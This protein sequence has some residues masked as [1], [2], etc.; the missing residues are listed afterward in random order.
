MRYCTG[1]IISSALLDY[2]NVG[3]TTAETKRPLRQRCERLLN[4]LAGDV[5]GAAP[6]WFRQ[7]GSTVTITS[8]NNSGVCPA[9]FDGR[10]GL[11]G[12]VYISGQTINPPLRYMP[13]N[14]LYDLRATFNQS[15]T[16]PKYYTLRD[17]D[18]STF[19]PL[20]QVYPSVSGGTVTL[21]LQN[22]VKALQELVDK[23]TAPTAAVGAATGLTGVYSYV[24]TYV[25]AVGETEAGVVSANVTVANQK[26]NV[27]GIPT[28][29]MHSVTSRNLYRTAAGGAVY[30]LV[31]TIADNTTTTYTD[32]IADVALGVSPPTVLTAVTGT[33]EFPDDFQDSL[34][35]EGLKTELAKSQGDVRD[36][37]WK[38]DWQKEVK[39]KWGQWQQGQQ[40]VVVLPR[41]GVNT[42]M[43]GN[44]G[45]W[46][47]VS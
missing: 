15:G 8:G 5:W 6:W 36:R 32:S 42:G 23:A 20:L 4:S 38:D 3:S 16:V 2:V 30:K 35:L 29:F 9:D 47:P 7:G 44:G 11:Q 24:V 18:P 43:V 40:Q 33:Q 26:I 45:R 14:Q 28:S 31:T 17:R 39:R 34:L 41:Y 19:L 1:E 10:F 25:T 21:S 12:G 13:P 27:S 46:L 37:A 22:Y